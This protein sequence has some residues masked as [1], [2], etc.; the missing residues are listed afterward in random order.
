MR[1]DSR[2]PIF[3]FLLAL[4]LLFSSTLASA[5]PAADEPIALEYR[6]YSKRIT[7]QEA[8]SLAKRAKTPPVPT[9]E[10]CKAQLSIPKDKAV[11][12][13][14]IVEKSAEQYATANGELRIYLQN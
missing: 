7:P 5:I 10:D 4:F 11:F 13:T 6:P 3:S 8:N 9:V 12:Y 1:F 2:T 14:S